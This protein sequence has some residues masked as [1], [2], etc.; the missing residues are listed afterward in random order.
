M[1]T[2]SETGCPAMCSATA[3]PKRREQQRAHVH[4][5]RQEAAIEQHQHREH[6]QHARDQRD[7]RSWIDSSA[8]HFWSPRFSFC[9]PCGKF[10]SVGSS[11]IFVHD[12][13]A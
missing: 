2:G 13:A 12:V 4:E 7:R 5:R 11:L 8:C 10:L 9:T 3:A 6:Q 1:S